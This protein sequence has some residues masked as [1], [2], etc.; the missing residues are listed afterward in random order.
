MTPTPLR[1]TILVLLLVAGGQWV[2]V[3]LGLQP[4]VDAVRAWASELGW[5]APA[6]FLALVIGRQLVLL[7]A[8][9]LL[10]AGGFIFGGVVG[11]MLGGTGIIVSGLANFALARRTG[12]V[13]LPPQ[14]RPRLR[15][16][17]ERGATPLAMFVGLATLHPLG[18]LTAAHWT[19]GCSAAAVTT[20]LAVLVPASYGR[21]AALATFGSTLGEWGSP[22]SLAL[23]VALLAAIVIPFSIPAVR[24]RLMPPAG[25]TD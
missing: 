14:W 11:T 23:T 4:S 22:G 1:V 25:P 7:P 21:A 8:L 9:V 12:D 3:H 2:R 19:A 5:H 15:R 24:R 20:F 6:A 17:G 16:L 10:T 13:M 18:P